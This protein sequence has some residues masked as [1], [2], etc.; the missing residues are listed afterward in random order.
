MKESDQPSDHA[1]PRRTRGTFTVKNL[2][3]VPSAPPPVE[4][5]TGFDFSSVQ[6]EEEKRTEHD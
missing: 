2:R 1:V 5:Q 4:G 6:D 3:L